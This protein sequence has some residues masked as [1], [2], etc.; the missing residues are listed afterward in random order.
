MKE[1]ISQAQYRLKVQQSRLD[2]ASNRMQ[3][4]DREMFD[5]CVKAQLTHDGARAAMYANEC[6]EV[7]KI[8]KVTLHAQ[9]ALESVT[10]RLETIREF[11]DIASMMGPVASVVR[12]I[13]N[14]ISGVIP[15]VGYELSEIG[16][17]LNGMVIEA[18]EATGA[19]YDMEASGAEAQRILDEANTIAEQRMKERFPEL[20][21]TTAPTPQGTGAQGIP[22]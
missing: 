13:H 3:Q 19:S 22:H 20:P 21:A 2:A 7:R 9:L 16:E 11:G 8:A 4:H 5:K 12:S 1:R 14:Q 15:A 10:L 17:M 18:G 6:A